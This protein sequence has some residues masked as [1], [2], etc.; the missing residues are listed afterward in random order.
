VVDVHLH[1]L[2]SRWLDELEKH[3]FDVWAEVLALIN[4][5]QE[6]GRALGDPECHPVVVA[7]YDLHALRR[8]PPSVTTPY[9]QAPP[10]LRVL[11][12]FVSD[13]EHREVAVV[14]IGGDKTTLG[15]AWY[16]ANVTQ[17][18]AR[19]DQWCQQNPTYRPII[20]RG[21]SRR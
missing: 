10:I 5:V 15:N 11:F 2:F 16:P 6:F 3:D 21:G 4:A 20:V 17:A 14:A 8:T 7:R 9:A 19:I 1:P 13:D 18:E 12:G